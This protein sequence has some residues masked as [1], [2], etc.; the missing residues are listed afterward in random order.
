MICKRK[1][2]KITKSSMYNIITIYNLQE[3]G[4]SASVTFGTVSTALSFSTNW[5]SLNCFSYLKPKF[6]L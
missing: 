2:I 3:D 4:S 6:H 1:T 5:G